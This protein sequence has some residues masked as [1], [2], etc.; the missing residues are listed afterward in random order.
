MKHKSPLSYK[1]STIIIP[2]LVL[3]LFM[4]R[5]FIIK[6][7]TFLPPCPFY[8]TF[9]L[10]CPACGN[11]RSVTALLHGNLLQAIH[12]NISPL[13][14]GFFIILAYTELATYSFGRRIRLLPQTLSFYLIII[15]LLSI[16]LIL[17]N[18][19]PFL[20]L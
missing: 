1:I 13:I 19:I 18:F 14:F 15:I 16:Y 4:L 20:S 7:A 10:Y 17:R 12:F 9:H 3:L 6:M 5:N 2:F 11:T 8:N